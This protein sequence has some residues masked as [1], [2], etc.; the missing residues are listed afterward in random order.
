MSAK[1]MCRECDSEALYAIR[2]VPPLANGRI[3]IENLNSA[4][5]MRLFPVVVNQ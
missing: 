3:S 5:G 2:N 4:D 1:F